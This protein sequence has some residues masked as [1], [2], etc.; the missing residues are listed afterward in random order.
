MHTCAHIQMENYCLQ[1]KA[2]ALS[3]GFIVRD[4]YHNRYTILNH[5]ATKNCIAPQKSQT[6]QYVDTVCTLVYTVRQQ[7]ARDYVQAIKPTD[8]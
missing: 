1:V 2:L 8:D 4:K 7:G 5:C 3:S 6:L